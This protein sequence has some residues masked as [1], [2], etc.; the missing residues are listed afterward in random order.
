MGLYPYE[1]FG[2]CAKP[3]L[4]VAA[5]RTTTWFRKENV[6]IHHQASKLLAGAGCFSYA[7]QK[8]RCWRRDIFF[9][10][11]VVLVILRGDTT[12]PAQTVVS[13]RLLVVLC[14]DF[15]QPNTHPQNK[16]KRAN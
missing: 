15:V 1:G 2:E 13:S 4:G 7:T 16:P 14:V 6:D 5:L 8:Q 11:L 9:C 3:G 10:S 12:L